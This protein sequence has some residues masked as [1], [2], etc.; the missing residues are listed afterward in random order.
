LNHGVKTREAGM[1]RTTRPAVV[2]MLLVTSVFAIVAASACNSPTRR[3]LEEEA[4]AEDSKTAN[5][6]IDMN[7]VADHIEDPP[8]AFHYSYKSESG[9]DLVDK[10]ADITPQNMEVTTKDPSGVHSYQGVRS[11]S[12]SWNVAMLDLMGSGLTVMTSRIEFVKDN[13]STTRV[14]AEAI[15][16]YKTTRYSIDTANANASDKQTFAAMFGP[17]SYEKGTLWA[18]DQGCPVKLVLDEARQETNG[19]VNKTRYELAMVRK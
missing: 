4:P 18:T 10:E 8:E 16:G 12:A 14:G 6:Q 19:I 7:C 5:V 2:V 1:K 13:S 11:D 3:N 15:N 9:Q 17:S